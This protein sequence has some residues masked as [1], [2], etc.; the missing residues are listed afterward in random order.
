ML[1][2]IYRSIINFI[3]LISPLIILIRVLKKKEDKIRFKEK[4]CF[5]SKKKIKKKL[6]WF[7]GASVGEILSIIPL[8]LNLEKNNEIDQILITS[9]T[10]SSSKIFNQFKFKKT[11]HQFFPID[12]NRLS[13]KFLNHWKPSLAI[14]IDSEIWPN[15]IL[16]L[17]EKSIPILLL[18]ARI[19][20]KSFRR[21]KILNKFSKKIF[22]C[23]DK[24]LVSNQETAKYLRYFG[25]NNIKSIGNLKFIQNKYKNLYLS[26]NLIKFFSNKIS[27]CASST[28]KGEELV[29]MNVHKTLK[30]KYKN[31]ISIIIPR[32]IDRSSEIVEIFNE[33]NLKVHCHS[34][35]SKIPE[36]VDIYLVDAY[37][38]TEK[39]FNLIKIVFVGGSL[40][41]HGGQ[42]P[43]E[44][45]R[46]GCNV[47]YGPYIDNFKN[48]YSYLDKI[49]VSKKI[50]DNK[51][52]YKNIETLIKNKSKTKSVVKR[53]KN[54]G[55]KILILTIKEI[56]NTLIK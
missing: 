1:L 23:V 52:L 43:L 3:F 30:K 55:D 47:L 14:F 33:N 5:F 40:V 44:P 13:K 25:V 18:N 42:N 17:K 8:V 2:F 38:E 46:H 54:L 37:G 31:L 32:H 45:A 39:F 4:F 28:H 53:V 34:W 36:K 21:W 11:V 24:S 15:M 48:I 7:H 20:E 27:W 49:K 12:T 50:H 10:L 29:S 35:K 6:I 26:K 19:T 51:S 9:S 56:E 41:K 22:Q 16:S